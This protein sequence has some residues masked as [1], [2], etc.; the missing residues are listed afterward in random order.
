MTTLV[1]SNHNPLVEDLLVARGNDVIVCLTRANAR[2]RAA[3]GPAYEVLEVTDWQAY[4]ELAHLAKHLRGHV[5]QIATCWEGAIVAAAFLRGLLGL[6]G[7]GV[8][9]AV[10]FTD[11]AVMKRRLAAAGIPVA[12]HQVV[13]SIS[14][15][16]DAAKA[17][18]GWPVVIKP[19]RGFASTQTYVLRSGRDLAELSA[20]GV[21]DTD[22]AV[23]EAFRAE[24]A[25]L[26]LEHQGE[27]LVEEYVPIIAEYHCDAL[28]QDGL[29]LYN[30]PGRYSVPP[31]QGMGKTLGS[32][33]VEPES[34]EGRH[35]TGMAAAAAAT[36]GMTDVDGFVHAEVFYAEDGR[37]LLGEIAARIGGGGIQPTIGLGY[38]IDVP[39]LVAA[40]AAGERVVVT[41]Q[42]RPGTYGWAGTVVPPG[43]I[44]SIAS[45]QQIL[46]SG[47]PAVVDATVA[48]Q[49]GMEGGPTSTGLWAGLAGYVYL[50]GERPADV[51]AAILHDVPGMF[52]ISVD[53]T[54]S[55]R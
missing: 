1:L 43:R 51:R 38:G 3:S 2:A 45:R 17:L 30:I 40:K 42:R 31:L 26:G 28:W 29:P 23:A 48:A 41:P 5:D 11:K 54:A 33:L 53:E 47:H 46:D 52:A 10:A 44:T 20:R 35:V 25:F 32:W 21:F 4:D 36:L 24:S 27:I 7:Q 55:V 6:T 12:R 15:V 37:W 9:D 14:E 39:G 8:A 13:G 18:G 22:Q 50:H 16:P 19:L 49:V 34:E